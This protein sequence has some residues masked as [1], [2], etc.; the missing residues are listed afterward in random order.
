MSE[1]FA[2]FIKTNELRFKYAKGM[3]DII[4]KEFHPYHEIFFFINGN[5][6]FIS[7]S[8]T[9]KLLPFTTVVIPKETFHCFSVEENEKN[10]IRCV[11]SFDEVSELNSLIEKKMNQI[12]LFQNPRI[13]ELFLTLRTLTENSITSIETNILLKSVFAQI[14]VYLNEKPSQITEE[15]THQITKD[16]LA[17][18]NNNSG[19]S[20]TIKE[21][22]SFL[23]VSESHLSRTFRHDL[24]ISINKYI[25]EK[26]LVAAN[27]MIRHSTNASQAA[28]ES[29]FSDYSNF[30]RQYKKRFGTAPS[31]HKP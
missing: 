3:R 22:A 4:G 6:L 24:H 9:K 1:E 17:Y 15:Y 8:I 25:L 29:G 18:I 27:K 26:K 7:E 31:K 12:L 28:T 20:F 23:H 19:K 16:A 30:Y 10:Y 13:T 11:F 21:M 2:K 5:V 14:L